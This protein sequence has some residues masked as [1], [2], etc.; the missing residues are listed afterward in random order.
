MKRVWNNL[1]QIITIFGAVWEVKSGFLN[2]IKEANNKLI[3]D[4]KR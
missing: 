1:L 4:L 2:G 3:A